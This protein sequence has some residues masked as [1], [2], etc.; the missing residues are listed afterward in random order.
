MPTT[1]S[2]EATRADLFVRCDLPK[3]ARQCRQT[4]EERLER[5]ASAGGLEDYSVS[6][7]AKRVPLDSDTEE[8]ECYEEFRRWATDEDVTL[9]PFF[10]TRECYSMTTGEKRRELVLPVL[11]LAIYDD[12]ELVYVAPHATAST[13]ATIPDCVDQLLEGESEEE[14][15]SPEPKPAD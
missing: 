13:T 4:I 5:V 10:D 8:M 6:S 15:A 7:W 3:P 11:C 1:P 2:G 14:R 9:A 12:D